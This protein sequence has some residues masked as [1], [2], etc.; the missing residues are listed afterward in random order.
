MCCG[1]QGLQGRYL[2]SV[3]PKCKVTSKSGYQS[4]V[5][6][7]DGTKTQIIFSLWFKHCRERYRSKQRNPCDTHHLSKCSY[8]GDVRPLTLHLEDCTLTLTFNLNSKDNLIFN[9]STMQTV[10]LFSYGG[11]HI[12][13]CRFALFYRSV[14]KTKDISQG[15][16]Q[17]RWKLKP[18]S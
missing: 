17:K 7:S 14:Y 4:T 10:I 13:I 15:D 9:H 6:G 2:S 18:D 11:A 16:T 8:S 12:L 5:F 3:S 1:C